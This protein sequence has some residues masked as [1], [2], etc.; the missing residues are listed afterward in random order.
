MVGVSDPR[1]VWKESHVM[2]P[3]DEHYG[4]DENMRPDQ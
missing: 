3:S 4:A 1:P 2:E